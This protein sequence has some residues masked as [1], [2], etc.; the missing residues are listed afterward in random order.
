MAVKVLISEAFQSSTNGADVLDVKGK[1]VG[2]CLKEATRQFPALEKMWF[3]P[4]G[5]FFHYMI[6]FL[7]GD[8]VP[9]N[10]LNTT[11]KADDEIYPVLMIGG[12]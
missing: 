8:N 12:G 6:L 5:R 9:K 10:D 11:V 1:T 4:E 3:D 2:E 7:N